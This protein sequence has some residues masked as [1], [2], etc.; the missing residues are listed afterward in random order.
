MR[1]LPIS[2]ATVVRLS[3]PVRH[4]CDARYRVQPATSCAETPPS[5]SRL[6]VFKLRPFSWGVAADMSYPAASQKAA[7]MA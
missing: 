6:A 2:F 5:I 4:D 1:H 3:T 7:H